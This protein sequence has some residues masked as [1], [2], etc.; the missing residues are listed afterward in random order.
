[1]QVAQLKRR[2]AVC[3]GIWSLKKSRMGGTCVAKVE[4]GG[5]EL[6]LVFFFSAAALKKKT[7]VFELF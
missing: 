7:R 6:W 3:A 2:C 5:L 4:C 1:M